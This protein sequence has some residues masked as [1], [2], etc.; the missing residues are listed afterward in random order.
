MILQRLRLLLVESLETITGLWWVTR[1]E[2]I[3]PMPCPAL[4]ENGIGLGG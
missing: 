3:V 1:L 4:L 2:R